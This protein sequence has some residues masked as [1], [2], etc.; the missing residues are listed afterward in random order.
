M[1]FDLTGLP[2]TPAEVDA[3]ADDPAPDAYEKLVDRLLASPRYG[4]HM[5]RYWLD[6]ARY[7]DT[8]GLHFDNERALWKYRDWVITAFNRNMP[9]DQFTD[10]A[11]GRRPAA[12]CHARPADRQRLQPLQRVDQ[13]RRLDQRGS[14]GPLCRRSDRDHVHG[15]SWG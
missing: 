14:A 5:A 11:D 4:E 15:L 9:F 7:G 8:H 13:R 2:P 6:V 10:R 3:F 12:Q 1:T